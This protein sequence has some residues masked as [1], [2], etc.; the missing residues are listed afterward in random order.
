MQNTPMHAFLRRRGKLLTLVVGFLFSAVGALWALLVTDRL[1]GQIQQLGA[2]KAEIAGQIA[3]LNGYA[4]D[5]FMLNQQGDLIFMLKLGPDVDRELAADIYKAN[6]SD[7]GV[8]VREMISELGRE[9][10]LDPDKVNAEY[11]A[12]SQGF[13]ASPGD[14]EKWVDLKIFEKKT[15][16]QGQGRALALAKESV[17]IDTDLRSKQRT[18]S[19][20]HVMAV[21]TAIIGSAVLVAANAITEIAPPDTGAAEGLAAGG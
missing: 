10:Q 21:L 13:Q 18:Q 20:N 3:L 9:Q 8:P 7:R 19:L 17:G 16:V 4:S 15:I 5:W 2:Q 14:L 11:R 12:L 1:D 6:I